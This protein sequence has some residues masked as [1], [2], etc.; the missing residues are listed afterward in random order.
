MAKRKKSVATRLDEVDRTM[1]STFCSAANSLSLLYTQAMNQQKVTFQAGERHAV[2]KVYSWILSQQEQ[3]GRLTVAD[4]LAYLQAA[5]A[6]RRSPRGLE[7]PSRR[8]RLRR[9]AR[10][11][12]GQLDQAKNSAVFSNALSSPVRRSLQPYHLAQSGGFCTGHVAGL[13]A[14][15]TAREADTSM[16]MHSDPE[17]YP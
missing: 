15:E 11:R 4:I 2:E 7:L 1:Y 6:A 14:H 10:P 17:P 16:D 5:V 9:P 13:R 3:G 8:R 12:G